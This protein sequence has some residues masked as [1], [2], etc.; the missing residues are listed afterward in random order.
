VSIWLDKEDSFDWPIS[1]LKLSNSNAHPQS[2]YNMMSAEA[3]CNCI[4]V[5]HTKITA[6][7]APSLHNEVYGNG[8]QCSALL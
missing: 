8:I 7:L 4:M 3:I 5:L 2:P 1:L 6:V